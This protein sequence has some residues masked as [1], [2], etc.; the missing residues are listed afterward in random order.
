[1]SGDA[2]AFLG[3]LQDSFIAPGKASGGNLKEGKL[4]YLP[5][6]P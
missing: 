5:E 6:E 4:A 2:A 3:S 1:M